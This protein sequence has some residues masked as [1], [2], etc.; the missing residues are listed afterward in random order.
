MAPDEHLRIGEFSTLTRL[1]VRMLRYYAEH[2]ILEPSATD[3]ATGYRFYAPA[4]LPDAL[5][6]RQLRDVGCSVSAIAA[7]LPLRSQPEALGRALTVQRGQLL[8]DAAQTRR[9]ITELDSLLHTIQEA[10]MATI[11]TSTLPAQRVAAL[12]MTIPNYPAEGQAWAEFMSQIAQQQIP[13]SPEPCGATFHDDGYQEADV[14]LTVWMPVPDGVA[15]AEP[16]T[17]VEQ[18]E[19]YVLAA[20]V[21]GDYDGIGPGCDELAA[22]LSANG[23]EPSGEMFNRYLVGPGRTQNPT[24]Y[25]TE[26][27]IPVL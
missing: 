5:L 15:V 6:V 21:L 7:L 10:T 22:H 3:P 19:Q 18:P 26:V 8:A 12:R 14:D 23:L 17:V 9:R 1:S 16:L 4:Q 13:F 25:V 11:T 24:D 2:R 27:C 20:T